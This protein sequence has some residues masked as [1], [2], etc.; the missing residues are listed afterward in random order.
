MK[1]LGEDILDVDRM[2]ELSGRSTVDSVRR[3]AGSIH[4]CCDGFFR[5]FMAHCKVHVEECFIF[6]YPQF[7]EMR[8]VINT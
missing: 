7:N 5:L 8:S 3:G 4:G 2:R 6:T 1:S